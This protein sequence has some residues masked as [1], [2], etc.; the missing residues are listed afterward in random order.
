MYVQRAANFRWVPFIVL[1]SVD[2]VE[3]QITE[4]YSSFCLTRA[5]YVYDISKH[6][7]EL[8]KRTL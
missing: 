5:K 2:V 4:V 7:V 1:E 8:K 3:L 6:S